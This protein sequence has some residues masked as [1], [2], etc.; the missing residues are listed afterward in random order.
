MSKSLYEMGRS[1]SFNSSLE[2]KDN[3]GYTFE[4]FEKAGENY[5]N[6]LSQK[7]LIANVAQDEAMFLWDCDDQ[8]EV[9]RCMELYG[10]INA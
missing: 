8:E 4:Q 7:E 1:E 3:F 5:A 10:E 9:E 6:Q 2:K